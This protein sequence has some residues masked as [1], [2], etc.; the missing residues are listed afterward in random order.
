M[1]VITSFYG[2]NTKG[3]PWIDSPNATMIVAGIG[4]GTTVVLVIVL[5]LFRWF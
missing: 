2:M 3:L 4:A 1:L 5:R